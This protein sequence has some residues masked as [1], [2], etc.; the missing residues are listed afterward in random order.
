MFSFRR[1]LL[2]SMLFGASLCAGWAQGP[3]LRGKVVSAQ[4]KALAGARVAL[5]QPEHYTT[6]GADGR[7]V[8]RLPAK[9]TYTIGA[10]AEGFRTQVLTLELAR[11]S[12][13]VFRLPEV[14]YDLKAVTLEAEAERDFGIRQLRSIEGV[15][16]YDAKKTEV[17]ELSRTTANLAT[18]N[19]RQVMAKVAGLNIWESDAAGQIGRAHV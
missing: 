13:L 16:I 18:N 9:G 4:G 8:L 7:F 3:L 14:S 2:I 19:A 11:D 1:F 6:T 17:V 5:K 15:A 12:N 10:F